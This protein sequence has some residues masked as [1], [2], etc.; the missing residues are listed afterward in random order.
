MKRDGRG[1]F[2]APLAG[3][4]STA[5]DD[6]VSRVC[7]SAGFTL[8]EIVVAIAASFLIVGA[9]FMLYDSFTVAA[10]SFRD[11]QG[12]FATA[13]RALDRVERDLACAMRT[14]KEEGAPFLLL[15]ASASPNDSSVLV[16]HTVFTPPASAAEDSDIPSIEKVRY[17]V[18]TDRNNPA[19]GLILFRESADR[20]AATAVAN[21]SVREELASNVRQ[22]IVEAFDGKNWRNSW[23]A[24][25]TGPMPTG[26]RI[27]LAVGQSD[28]NNALE[29]IVPIS[30]GQPSQNK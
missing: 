1:P 26:A 28:T 13:T 12:D 16:F 19:R 24:G 9:V 10:C 25:D 22:F 27:V 17:S 20:A 11:R 4:T 29:S 23:P 6:C 15:P 30:V 7:S 3:P 2:P 5:I 8:L 21:A 14:G 18:E